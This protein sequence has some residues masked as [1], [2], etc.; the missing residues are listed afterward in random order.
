MKSNCLQVCPDPRLDKGEKPLRG[1]PGSK[2]NWQVC[3]GSRR[4]RQEKARRHKKGHTQDGN[5][6]SGMPLQFFSYS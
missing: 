5:Q 6:P 4:D 1:I 3:P 2:N